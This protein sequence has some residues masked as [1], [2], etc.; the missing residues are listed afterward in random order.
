MMRTHTCGEL[1]QTDIDSEVTLC[2][3]VH[4]N[5]DHGGLIFI[6]LRD[7]YGLSQIVFNP[8]NKENH[9]IA[10]KLRRE[11]VIQVSGTVIKRKEGMENPNLV[12]G[13]VEVD[14]HSLNILA[15]AE[16]PPLEVDDRIV[17]NDEMRLKYRYLDLRRPIMQ[18]NLKKRFKAAQVAREYL[19][20]YD[21]MEIETPHLV[22]STPEGARDYVVP[23]RVNPSKFYALPQSPQLYKQLLMIAGF[24]RYF[25]FARCLRDEDLRSDRQPEHTQ[26][27]LEMSFVE[28]KDIRDFVEGLFKEMTEKAFGVKIKEPFTVISFDEAMEKYGCDKPDLRFGLELTDVTSIVGDSDFSVF[29][30]VVK[31]GGLVKCINPGHDF[32]RKEIDNL[33]EFAKKQGANGMAWMRVTDE[34]LESNIVKYF[35]DDVQKRLLERTKAKPGSVLMFIADKPGVTNDVLAELRKE[36]GKRLELYDE[37][38]MKFCWVVDFPLFEWNEDENK[39]DSMHN[40]FSM[41]KKEH[42]KY[43][44]EDPGKVY[45]DLFD[46][47]LNGVE[48]GSG[49]I[50]INQPDIQEKILSIIGFDKKDAE[51]SFGFLMDAYKY[52]GPP[53][54]GMGLGFD[55]YIAMLTGTHDI[56]E[57]IAF[58]KNKAA[59]C[60]MDGCPN[61]ITQGQLKELHLKLDVVNT[62]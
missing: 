52:G 49:S 27:D 39:W 46:L 48:L 26:I 29:Q 30:N 20:N 24:D 19:N 44:D 12:T 10:E 31:S 28:E 23:S 7:R 54:G 43:L 16:T 55:R 21:F 13:Q 35:N 51:D 42:L 15:K 53:H 50:R 56:R 4:S 9:A 32:S 36:L 57:V 59:Q 60:P 2:G 45:G 3:W 38:E 5:R 61:P 41:P 40:F 25:Q 11:D 47:V 58:P 33:I 34:G 18:E 37:S 22:K 6:D 62:N 1:K 17:A 14:V 8:I